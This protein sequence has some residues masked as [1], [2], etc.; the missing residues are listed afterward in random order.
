MIP[1]AAKILILLL[2][3]GLG[4]LGGVWAQA[5]LMPFLAS[6]SASADIKFVKE[7]SER[8][9]VIKEVDEIFI[10][11][12]EA[13]ERAVD[14]VQNVVVGVQSTGLPAGEAGRKGVVG[15]SGFIVASDGLILTRASVVPQ[16]YEP[17][18]YMV[19]G[20]EPVEAE[21]IKRDVKED[22]ALLKIGADN[23]QTAGFVNEERIRLGATVIVVANI[24]EDGELISIANEGTVRTI[25]E[26]VLRTNIFDKAALRGA[27]LVNL[28]GDI[29][30]VITVLEDRRVVATPS[31][32]LRDFAG[33]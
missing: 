11:R 28:E 1:H 22:L 2:V 3:F 26:S 4:T 9:T 32:T 5:F 17:L 21:V 23:L 20:K 30:G 29:V 19:E 14:R 6:Q 31:S 27:P 8:T 25:G 10:N 13:V 15:G 18:V 16:G 33:L 12:D 7:W 24:V